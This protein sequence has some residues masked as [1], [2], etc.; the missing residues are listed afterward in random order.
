MSQ[1]IRIISEIK[2][3]QYKT[4]PNHIYI[5]NTSSQEYIKANTNISKT[6]NYKLP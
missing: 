6:N 3:I 4:Y 2:I 5:L 1:L